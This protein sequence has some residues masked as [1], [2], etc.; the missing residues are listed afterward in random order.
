MLDET[1]FDG[2]QQRLEVQRKYT[3]DKSQALEKEFSA[4]Q[5]CRPD[6]VGRTE[7][8]AHAFYGQGITSM[9]L[10]KEV[11]HPRRMRSYDPAHLP[12]DRM[13]KLIATTRALAER[14]TMSDD[15]FLSQLDNVLEAPS[16]HHHYVTALTHFGDRSVFCASLHSLS[17]S[18]VKLADETFPSFIWRCWDFS[19]DHTSC[20]D[21][22]EDRCTMHDVE[23][24][25]C[26]AYFKLPKTMPATHGPDPIAAVDAL[27][28]LD[29]DIT[30][31][32]STWISK[33][34]SLSEH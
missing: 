16:K 33:L 34:C 17:H 1:E 25:E 10:P 31:A 8:L 26:I 18:I 21:G 7:L 19:C 3:Y 32:S 24:S 30:P 14:D 22:E 28:A 11:L 4:L 23:G 20:G 15:V 9:L 12:V 2:L 5:V 29:V 6:Q 27:A 13:A